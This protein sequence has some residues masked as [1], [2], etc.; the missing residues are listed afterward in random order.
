M[1]IIENGP[2]PR[3]GRRALALINFT[4][5]DHFNQDGINGIFEALS[6]D[7]RTGQTILALCTV[8]HEVAP[9]V[10]T[11]QGQ[12]ALQRVIAKQLLNEEGEQES[13]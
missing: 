7:G 5:P 1:Q 10:R 8:L 12:Q 6:A 2:E 13:E 4:H 3:D 9:H 11:P